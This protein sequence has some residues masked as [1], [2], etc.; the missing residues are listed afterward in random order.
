MSRKLTRWKQ[1][2]VENDSQFN[3]KWGEKWHFNHHNALF[4]ARFNLFVDRCAVFESKNFLLQKCFFTCVCSF[5]AKSYKSLE[6]DCNAVKRCFWNRV[7]FELCTL[8]TNWILSLLRIWWK[9]KIYVRNQMQRNRWN[10]G[11]EKT[12]YVQW[13]QIEDEL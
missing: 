13:N 5:T 9:I 10:K 3:R 4:G 12:L 11:R 6:T 7:S 1:I 8:W 2:S